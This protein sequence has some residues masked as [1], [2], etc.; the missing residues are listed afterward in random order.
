MSTLR[1]NITIE[2][3]DKRQLGIAPRADRAPGSHLHGVYWQ[4]LHPLYY[5]ANPLKAQGAFPLSDM[6]W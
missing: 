1:L 2:L 6:S 5:F 3:L 4:L